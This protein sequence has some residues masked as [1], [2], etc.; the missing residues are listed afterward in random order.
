MATVPNK[1]KEAEKIATESFF[2]MTEMNPS[3]WSISLDGDNIVFQNTVT[4]RIFQ[5]SVEAFNNLMRES[6]NN[7]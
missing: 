5:G 2:T 7:L 3:N 1:T 4:G 6:L